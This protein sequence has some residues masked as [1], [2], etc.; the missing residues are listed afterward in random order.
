LT[1]EQD[2]WQVQSVRAFIHTLNL[3]VNPL[4]EWSAINSVYTLVEKDPYKLGRAILQAKKR[5]R[6]LS[7]VFETEYPAWSDHKEIDPNTD[8][9][10]S[11]LRIENDINVSGNRHQLSLS[12]QVE[13][14]SSLLDWLYAWR[15][16]SPSG[17]IL[18]F[19]AWY[20][21]RSMQDELALDA[22]KV[23]IMTIHGAKG[24]EADHVFLIG[25]Q[26]GHFPI[27]QDIDEERRLFFVGMTRTIERLH[28]SYSPM[29]SS[30]DGRAPFS[31]IFLS[32]AGLEA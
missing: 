30:R 26:A 1:S 12:G 23:K 31:S 19:L 8:V 18:A 27:G 7:K 22:D 4:S 17:S 14:I 20:W 2:L 11:V 5:R 28:I 10:E 3:I 21:N 9:L 29:W 13:A 24:L 32:E 25:A 6:S 15:A 16:S